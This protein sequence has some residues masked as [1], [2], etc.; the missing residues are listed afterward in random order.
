M[1]RQLQCFV[2]IW[3]LHPCSEVPCAYQSKPLGFCPGTHVRDE[4]SSIVFTGFKKPNGTPSCKLPNFPAITVPRKPI[5]S[6]AKT[7]SR[8]F[9]SDI[10]GLIKSWQAIPASTSFAQITEPLRSSPRDAGIWG[11]CIRSCRLEWRNHSYPPWSNAPQVVF[12]LISTRV[13]A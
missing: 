4:Q 10:W 5:L 7:H 6:F 1:A 11:W 2:R 9:F 8:K 13:S 12:H 3:H